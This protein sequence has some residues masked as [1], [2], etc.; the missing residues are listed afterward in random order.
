MKFTVLTLFPEV[1]ESY[2]SSSIIKRAIEKSL[3]EVEIL[4]IRT[5]KFQ[6]VDDYAYGGESGMVLKIDP[7]VHVLKE[8]NL[9]DKHIILLTPAGTPLKQQI[10]R[11]LVK[12][13]SHVV[14]ICGHYEGVDARIE[15]YISQEISI[16]D[17][18]I[19][20]GELSA[21]VVLDSMTRLVPGVINKQSLQVESFDDYLLDFPVYTRPQEFENHIVPSVYLSGHRKAIEDYRFAERKRITKMKRPDLYKKFLKKVKLIDKKFI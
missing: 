18:V 2:I 3:V 11:D 4:N 8:N 15:H 16:G 19:T 21:L 17:Y 14:L 12:Q 20:S 9:L 1:V 7:I 6:Q 13:Y 10:S 5:S